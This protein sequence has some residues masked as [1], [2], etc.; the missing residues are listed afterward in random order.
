MVF[1]RLLLIIIQSLLLYLIVFTFWQ[2]KALAEPFDYA[3]Y[4]EQR[5][6]EKLEKERAQRIT[7]NYFHLHHL[8]FV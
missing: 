2:A 4:I 3:E 7:V 5:K 6:G 8:L 1:V